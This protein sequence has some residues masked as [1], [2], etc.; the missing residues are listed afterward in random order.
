MTKHQIET[1]DENR[2]NYGTG[3]GYFVWMCKPESAFRG[4]GIGSQL[5]IVM[6]K[7]DM[8]V[9]I[10]AGMLDGAEMMM[11]AIFDNL[12]GKLDNSEVLSNI[13]MLN[14]NQKLL[15]LKLNSLSIPFILSSYKI[16]Q[17]LSDLCN[18]LNYSGI[19][20]N[21]CQNRPNIIRISIVFGEKID[22]LKL[23]VLGN[24]A[25]PSKNP[26]K[27]PVLL[28]LNVGHDQWIENETNFEVDNFHAH[29]TILFSNVACSSKWL[30]K[31][32][33][34][35]KFVYTQTPYTDILKIKFSKYGINGEYCCS[36]CIKN[37]GKSFQI[38]G[39]PA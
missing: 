12:I 4:S 23:W 9:V 37:R 6:P 32:E 1:F 17:E 33:Y 11:K 16:N 2:P 19:V 24:S 29:S 31:D 7:Q 30:D 10:T 15:E 28:T 22:I 14:K 25:E 38:M 8:I 20:Y 39:I 21:I 34:S 36:P 5:L 26:P 3:Y 13:E 27:N 18:Y 35:V